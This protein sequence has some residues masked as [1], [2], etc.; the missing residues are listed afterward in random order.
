MAKVA[1]NRLMAMIQDVLDITRTEMDQARA[2]MTSFDPREAIDDMVSSFQF[3]AEMRGLDLR[4]DNRLTNALVVQDQ[5]RLERVLANLLDN[6]LKY[7]HAGHVTVT[8]SNSDQRDGFSQMVV[9]SHRYGYWNP[10]RTTSRY[11]LQVLTRKEP[12]LN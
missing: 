11:F 12:F 5:K 8:A 2:I 3:T 9:E 10:R 4:L 7:T 1:A 6:A